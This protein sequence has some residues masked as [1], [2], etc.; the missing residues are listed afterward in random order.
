MQMNDVRTTGSLMKIVDVL[1]NQRE[2]REETAKV[3]NNPVCRI[4]F[5]EHDQATTICVPAP[6]QVAL[7]SKRGGCRQFLE[8]TVRPQAVSASRN[9]RIPLSCDTPAPVNPTTCLAFVNAS[10]IEGG[11]RSWSITFR[12]GGDAYPACLSLFWAP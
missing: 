6:N 12:P 11:I 9:V 3:G 7:F 2:S 5:A 4:R 10:I 8:I 1:S